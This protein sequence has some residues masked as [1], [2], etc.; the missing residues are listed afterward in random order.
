HDIAIAV[1]TPLAWIGALVEILA[2]A[3]HA[4]SKVVEQVRR[5]R[6]IDRIRRD[7][8]RDL[9]G[10]AVVVSRQTRIVGAASIVLVS[11]APGPVPGDLGSGVAMHSSARIQ[12]K[13]VLWLGPEHLLEI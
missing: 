2:V 11:Q 4:E 9:V 7:I 12:Q 13:R 3:L 5:N 10:A 8:S 6:V 1:D